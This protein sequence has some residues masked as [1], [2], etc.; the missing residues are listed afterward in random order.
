MKMRLT[1]G[2]FVKNNAINLKPMEYFAPHNDDLRTFSTSSKG[3]KRSLDA[4][5]YLNH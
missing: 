5:P 4:N 1:S 2:S 3:P